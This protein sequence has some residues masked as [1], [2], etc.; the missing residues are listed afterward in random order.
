MC[1]HAQPFSIISV[2][3]GFHHVGQPGL[4]LLTSA[5]LLTSASQKTGSH[6]VA[7]AGLKLLG[8]SNPPA[9]ASPS[10]QP[11]LALLPR[12]EC[13]GAILAHHNLHLLGSANSRA[14][15]PQ[16]AGTTG[17]G[18][19]T[20]LTFVF[21][22]EIG[23]HQ[24]GQAAFKLL[25]SG[26]LLALASLSA[27]I[28][29][30]SHCTWPLF[31]LYQPHSPLPFLELTILLLC[32]KPLLL[33]PDICVT[34][35][36]TLSRSLLSH[37]FREA[38][39][40]S[41][42]AAGRV[43]GLTPGISALSEAKVGGSLEVRSF[44]PARPTWCG[45]ASWL[46][47]VIPALWEAE[48]GGSPEVRHLR[49]AW[50]SWRNPSTKTTKIGWAQW[51][52][53]LL[54]RLR[55]E[56]CFNVGDGGC[57]EPRLPHCTPAWWLTPIISTL[58]EAKV[59]GSLESSSSRP[60]WKRTIWQNSIHYIWSLA[61]SL[62]LECSGA[63]LGHF[64]LCLLGSSDSPAST[65]EV[66]EII[67][68]SAVARCGSLKPPPPGLKGFS[69]LSLLSSWDCR[70]LPPCPA[71]FFRDQAS[72][73]W[74]DWSQL[75]V[76][77]DLPTSVS[78]TA[79][80]TDMSH[81][82]W[83]NLCLNVLPQLT[84]IST[85]WAQAILPLQHPK[86]FTMLPRLVPNSRAQGIHLPQ[87][88]KVLAL[89]MKSCFVVQAEVQWCHL[90]SLQPSTPGLKQFSCL[91]LLSGMTGACHH[92][93]LLFVFLVETGFH[94][95]GQAGLELLTSG[96]Y[97]LPR[98]ECNGMLMAHCNLNLMDSSNPPSLASCIAETTSLR[99]HAW[100]I[101]NFLRQWSHY[102][103]QAALKFWSSSD[104][105][106]QSPKVL[107][108]QVSMSMVAF[109]F[110]NQF[111]R[112]LTGSRYVAHAGARWLFTGAI[113]LLISA[114]VLTC[115]IS[116]LDRLSLTL[117]PRVECSGTISAHCNL[118]LLGSS[119]SP[120]SASQL[121]EIKVL[122]EAEVGGSPENKN[123]RPAWPTWRNPVCTKN[124]KISPA[125]WHMAVISATWEAEAGELPEP[126]R[127]RLQFKQF[128]CLSLPS[129]WN[130]R[131]APP[132]LANFVFL[133]KTG[134]RHVGE[135]G[136]KPLTSGDPPA[137]P[138]QSAGIIGVSNGT[139][140]KIKVFKCLRK[141]EIICGRA[142]WLT[143]VIPALWE[144]EAGGSR[145]QEIET[146]LATRC[147]LALLSRMEFSGAIS[148]YRNLHLLG[149][150]DSHA[151]ASQVV[152]ITGACH[153]AQLIFVFLVD[154]GFCHVG[155][156]DLKFLGSNDTP[157]SA[158]QSAEITG[159]S[160]CNLPK[161]GFFFLRRSLAPLSRLE[162]HGEISA[163]CNLCLLG[164]SNSLPQPPGISRVRWLTPVIPTLREAEAGRSPETKQ[165]LFI[166]RQYNKSKLLWGGDTR[167]LE[168]QQGD[169]QVLLEPRRSSATVTLGSS[170]TSRPGDEVSLL[171]SGWSSVVRY[172]LCTT[173]DSRIQVILCLSL[174]SSWDYRCP[175]P[176][177]D[178]FFSIFCGDEGFTIL[179]RLVLNSSR[180][181][182]RLGLPK[183]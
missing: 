146:I 161:V 17:A 68:R 106:P 86:G 127:Q 178:N 153:H 150:R 180:G 59:G 121:T 124:I 54:R 60:N 170:L 145:G 37:L 155:Q 151:S 4:E 117:L 143:P 15:A 49:P 92:A 175:P 177:L 93:R 13:S 50:P 12:L 3:T 84:A 80:I 61:L 137:S 91:S 11:S 112:S 162:C 14:S 164:S 20:Q 149:S 6:Y 142:R 182:T 52:T 46:T 33:Y 64:N 140:T 118:C 176:R 47:P 75:L 123:S 83:P 82:A 163:H 10:V 135:A 71:N 62:R 8:P 160:D 144:A 87:P 25:T 126:G 103:S 23:F 116:N 100:L 104:P 43:Q 148:A 173:S 24:D 58:W 94:Y 69:C 166:D 55:E 169:L 53:P 28:T 2:E 9:S 129:S 76:S 38:I 1:H 45:R 120:A 44:R 179:A 21:L 51:L 77:S 65:S 79:G 158:S 152:R 81:R 113:P 172:R 167:S 183:Y 119:N 98:L 36:L 32:W 168:K 18:Q 105:L 139:W 134:F 72:P 7:Q 122:W 171:L 41:K 125:C 89:Q 159:V 70:P 131:R 128:S 133:V 165:L 29:G 40:L 57:S 110:L 34:G 96:S 67:G 138:S 107:G 30:E 111:L 174:P 16:V 78:Q 132:H 156:A 157:A 73:C 27:G 114:G 109:F 101:F 5:D 115:S 136:F 19:H 31:F 26:D 74:P 35:S 147:S 88:P 97:F 85:S 141:L 99:D 102:V 48:V 130:Y 56:S 108:L 39:M 181:D 63:I 90:G 42:I 22:V 95:V 66:A 154:L